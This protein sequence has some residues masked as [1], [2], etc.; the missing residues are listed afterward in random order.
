MAAASPSSACRFS[1][2]LYYPSL[3]HEVLEQGADGGK[4]S[5]DADSVVLVQKSQVP[6]DQEMVDAR[7]CQSRPSLPA[8][9]LLDSL[10]SEE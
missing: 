7:R 8:Y 5:A 10:R 3:P 4:L 9:E 1:R 6:P 2:V